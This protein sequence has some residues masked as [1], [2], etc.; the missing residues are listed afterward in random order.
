MEREADFIGEAS[1]FGKFR[2]LTI[3]TS[4]S[5]RAEIALHDVAMRAAGHLENCEGVSVTRRW[6]KSEFQLDASLALERGERN[7]TASLGAT[8][9]DWRAAPLLS[10]S[11]AE[12]ASMLYISVTR[13]DELAGLARA[14]SRVCV[15]CPGDASDASFPV[16]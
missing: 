8:R 7:A 15:R 2:L 6:L 10:S 4:C 9:T 11:T 14:S 3:D 12:C 1:K 13:S 5:G 16:L